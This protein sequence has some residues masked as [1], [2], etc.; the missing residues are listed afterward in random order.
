MPTQIS[1]GAVKHSKQGITT[2]RAFIILRHYHNELRMLSVVPAFTPARQVA[3]E[4]QVEPNPP[5]TYS[6]QSLQP[7]L[8]RTA[9]TLLDVRLRS[10]KVS[11]KWR[12]TVVNSVQVFILAPEVLVHFLHIVMGLPV[13]PALFMKMKYG[14][15]SRTLQR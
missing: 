8:P 6:E 3:Q 15:F 7:L 2:Q 12:A 5:R 11:T 4:S 1:N 14:K 10:N 13:Q 9:Y